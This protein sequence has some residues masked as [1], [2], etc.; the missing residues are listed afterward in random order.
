MC[1]SQLTHPA[2]LE[3][4]IQQSCNSL[5][6]PRLLEGSAWA[7][8]RFGARSGVFFLALT[9]FAFV[10]ELELAPSSS[11]IE[12]TGPSM[13]PALVFPAPSPCLRFASALAFA[14]AF[15][16]R[17]FFPV[18]LPTVVDFAGGFLLCASGAALS[19]PSSLSPCSG[20]ISVLP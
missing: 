14:L 6:L 19:C 9:D 2:A 11:A 13:S 18:G 15:R 16:V 20:L 10:L 1:A 7:F 5:S 8:L 3:T 4:L 17:G 12:F